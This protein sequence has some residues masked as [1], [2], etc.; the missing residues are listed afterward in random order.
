MVAMVAC[1][2][3]IALEDP[4]QTPLARASTPLSQEIVARP[5]CI[6]DAG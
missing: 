1:L 6:K 5:M 3:H 2:Q 4:S